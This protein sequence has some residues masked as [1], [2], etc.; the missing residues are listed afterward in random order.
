VPV[1]TTFRFK[2]D[3]PARV[4]FAFSQIDV[5]RRVGARCVKATSANRERPRCDRYQARGTLEITGKAGANTYSFHGRVRGAPLTPGRYRLLVT[6]LA[7]G[8][9]SAAALIAFT[10]IR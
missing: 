9:S 8:K 1:G 10:I 5:G 7:D 6:A 3:R 2:L 4:R